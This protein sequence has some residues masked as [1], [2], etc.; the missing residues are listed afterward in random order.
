[1]HGEVTIDEEVDILKADGSIGTF[2]ISASP[3]KNNKGEIIGSMEIDND[4]TSLKKMERELTTTK[5]SLEAIINQMPVCV[6]IAEATTGNIVMSN[7]AHNDL[8]TD[9]DPAR[10]IFSND[11]DVKFLNPDMTPMVWEE[12]PLTKAVMSGST[13]IGSEAFLKYRDGKVKPILTC[14]APVKDNNGHIRAG[15]SIIVDITEI[16]NHERKMQEKIQELT[17]LNSELHKYAY[18]TSQD[19][20]ESM[21]MISTYLQFIEKSS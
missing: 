17:H 10:T 3:I 14:A 1:M 4:I 9:P 18:V 16:K 7:Q 8:F 20:R 5:A 2:L 11:G 15:V 12:Y 13:S 19:L 21:K 6:A